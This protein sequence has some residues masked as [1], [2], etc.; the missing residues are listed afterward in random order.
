MSLSRQVRRAS[1]TGLLAVAGVALV[2]LLLL[3]YL[4]AVVNPAID[5]VGTGA[6]AE[7]TKH[8]AM[9]DQETGL[10]AYLITGDRSMLDVYFLARQDIAG[11]LATAREAFEDEPGL[12]ALLDEQEERIRRWAT[13]WAQPAMARGATFSS[14]AVDAE[15]R[16]FVRD[17][18]T[19]FDDYRDAY[20]EVQDAA[21]A[22]R[23]SLDDHRQAVI[24]VALVVEVLLL[25]GGV[26]AMTVQRRRLVRSV[27][28]P[29]DQLL[30]QIHTLGRGDLTARNEVAAPRELSAIGEGLDEMA[31]ALRAAREDTLRHEDELIAARRTAEDANAAKSAFLATMSHEIRTP[32]NA[33]IGMSELLL[34]TDLAADQREYAETVRN[35][36]STLLAIIN[37]VLDFSK[38]EAG[39]LELD[40]HPFVLRDCVE[41][42]LDL[43]AAQASAKGLDL[44]AHIDPAVPPV[45][46]GDVTRLRQVLANLVGNAVKFTAAGEVLVSVAPA[47][48]PGSGSGS[49]VIAFAVCDTGDGIPADRMDR[50]FRSFS[51]V[52]SSTT[53]VYGG[54]GL[55]LAISQRL[56]DAM[57]GRIDV[58]SE[59]G[60]GS[61]FTVVVPL[62]LGEEQ[63]DQVRVAP[64]ELPGRRALVVDDNA[65][66]RRILRAQLESWGMHVVDEESPVE[67]LVAAAERVPDVAILDMHMPDLDGVALA[68]GLR[69]TAGWEDVPLVLL[70][71]LGDRI[72]GAAELGLVHLTKPVKAVALRSTVARS[73]GARISEAERPEHEPI[74]R[75]RVLLAE[76]NPVN[77]RVA[78]L[79]LERLGQRPVI[80]ANGQEALVAVRTA[81]YDLVLM[82]VQM[83]VMDGHE[84]TRRIRAELPPEDQPRIVALSANAL[85]EQRED[86]LAAGMDAHLA[87]PVRSDELA[88]ELRRTPRRGGPAPERPEEPA[89]TAAAAAVPTEAALLAAVDPMVLE[90]LLR[91]LGDSGPALAESL[92]S[93]WRTDAEQQVEVLCRAAADEDRAGAAAVAHSLKS[94]SAAVGAVRLAAACAE[95]ERD[96]AD[97]APVDLRRAADRVAAE[98]DAAR[99]AFT[100]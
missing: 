97:G 79:M 12:P 78:G 87:K 83:P 68:T 89:P 9:I 98:V 82:D 66:N 35:S 11:P 45:V 70:T 31:G 17:G 32:M 57:G 5:R 99:V 46:V 1:L 33:V 47:T 26:L 8:M 63:E 93:A 42:C 13:E 100:R 72:P 28:T 73:L 55:G 69:A 77:Q 22:R 6:R 58:T 14:S 60:V 48:G 80:V 88:E 65:T 29:V 52:D 94:A 38:I 18:Q 4:A 56:V 74:G 91:H 39:E 19:L 16:Q 43:V 20:Q 86:S 41:S 44:V 64:A 90:T 34:D 3:G 53:R 84:A 85:V 40:H 71:S 25:V 96:L 49:C 10:R 36:G 76:D 27:V 50:L 7:R 67:A 24:Q 95:L 81:P 23:A 2:N 62:E 21:D 30:T 37:D 59:V 15:R 51:Q 92:V 61:T 54:T 75:L